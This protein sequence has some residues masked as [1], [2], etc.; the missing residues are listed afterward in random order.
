MSGTEGEMTLPETL[1]RISMRNGAESHIFSMD[2]EAPNLTEEPQLIAVPSVS[3]L[4]DLVRAIR[5]Q[6]IQLVVEIAE[7]SGNKTLSSDA[8]SKFTKQLE[9]LAHPIVELQ[10]GIRSK[11]AQ[12]ARLELRNYLANEVEARR[13]ALS[14]MGAALSIAKQSLV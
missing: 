14:R 13:R 1:Q 11:N 10:R 5:S 8:S 7:A 12:T 4:L 2:S 6:Y 3:Q 9:A